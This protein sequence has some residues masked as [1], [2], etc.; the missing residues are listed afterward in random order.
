MKQVGD[1]NDSSGVVATN[2]WKNLFS[3]QLKL[4]RGFIA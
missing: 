2:S 1:N 3:K 4:E